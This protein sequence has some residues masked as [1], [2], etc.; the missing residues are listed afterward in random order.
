MNAVAYIAMLEET[1]VD[2][3]DCCAGDN[4][5]FQQDNAPMHSFRKTKEWLAS[6]ISMLL[7]G[8][9]LALT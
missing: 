1:L 7:I 9:Q 8:P 2:Y 3:G 5:V 6:K 4:W